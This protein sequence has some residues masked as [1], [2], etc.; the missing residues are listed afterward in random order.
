[1][2]TV[3]VYIYMNRIECMYGWM[4]GLIED[5]RDESNKEKKNELDNRKYN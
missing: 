1:M 5:N 2:N 4:D 3:C